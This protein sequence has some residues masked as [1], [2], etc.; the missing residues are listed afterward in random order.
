MNWKQKLKWKVFIICLALVGIWIIWEANKPQKEKKE[1]EWLEESMIK[2]NEYAVI[3]KE[4][5][6]QSEEPKGMKAE[7]KEENPFISVLIMDTNYKDYFHDKIVFQFTGTYRIN[8]SENR[9]PEKDTQ[10]LIEKDSPCFQNGIIQIEPEDETCRAVLLSVNRNCGNPSYRGS[11][12]ISQTPD[13]IR[14]VN[15]LP[16][17]EYLYGVVPSEMPVSFGTEALKAQ[18]VCA[19]TYAWVQMQDSALQEAGAQVDDSVSYQ[20]YQNSKESPIA[21]EAVNAT[22]GQILCQNH[23]PVNA[24]YFSTS[25]GKTSTDEVWEASVPASYLQSVE[26]TYDQEEPWYTWKVFM[27]CRHLLE[28]IQK[29]TPQA[30]QL[31]SMTILATGDGD[32]VLRLEIDTDAGTEEI[33]N[34][35]DIRSFLSPE[36]LEIQRQDGSMVKGGQLLPS[37]YFTLEEGKNADGSL[38]GYMIHGGGYGHGVGMSQNGAKGMAE[39]GYPYE[40]ILKYFYKDITIAPLDSL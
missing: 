16:L 39:Q 26:C 21:N 33:T 35:Y 20:V 28:Q 9:A 7:K 38:K 6:E 19:R 14:I 24:Y 29:N 31:N 8:P 5:P 37:A 18:A 13:G 22:K 40:E 34:E 17:E 25:H 30:E 4:T 10:F 3:K 32:A 15:T 27:S 11:F 23:Q 1:R 2:E 12:T 36:G